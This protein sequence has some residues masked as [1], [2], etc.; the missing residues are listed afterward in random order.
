MLS[1]LYTSVCNFYLPPSLVHKSTFH[2][3]DVVC[4]C[5][6]SS[7]KRSCT[8]SLKRR[9]TDSINC[10]AHTQVMRQPLQSISWEGL[11]AELTGRPMSCVCL[12]AEWNRSIPRNFH[13]GSS[14]N[15]TVT[16]SNPI[17]QLSHHFKDKRGALE[18]TMCWQ[19]LPSALE[20]AEITKTTRSTTRSETL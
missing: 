19:P 12:N 16:N 18:L 15:L 6:V 2:K 13:V 4:V 17:L 20:T 5:V 11:N 14:L 3:V 7:L 10:Y 8:R 1:T 9:K